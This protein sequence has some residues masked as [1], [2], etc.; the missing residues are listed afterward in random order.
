MRGIRGSRNGLFAILALA[1]AGS[2]ALV[3]SGTWS[4]NAL[5]DPPPPPAASAPADSRPQP[6]PAPD[7]RAIADARRLSDAFVQIAELVSPSVVS[8]KVSRPR[9]HQMGRMMPFQI[10]GPDFPGMDGGDAPVERGM[11][12]GVILDPQGHILTNNHVVARATELGVRLKDGRELPARLIGVDQ[13][14][15][16]AVIKVEAPN[17]RPARLGSSERMRVGDWV[18][19]IGSPFGLDYTVTAGVLSAKGRAG[20]GMNSVE[21]YLQTDASINPGNSGGPLVNLDA[22]VIGINTMIVGQGTGIGFAIPADMARESAR[23]LI[24]TGRVQRAWIGVGIQDLTPELAA[25]FRAEPRSG[26][27]LS[28]VVPGGPAARAGLAVGDIVTQIGAARVRSSQDVVRAVLTHRPGEQVEIRYV[29]SGRD[30]AARVTI[31]ERPG[32]EERSQVEPAPPAPRQPSTLGL[33]LGV[34]PDGRGVIMGIQPGGVADRAGLRPGD[35]IVEVDRRSVR[36]AQEAADR[37]RQSPRAL[38]RVERDGQSLFI[39]LR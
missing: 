37:L 6:T 35:V 7:S 21:D 18:V 14:A 3:G 11:G 10:P 23:Q 32:A 9:Q 8:I 4:H 16:L 5:A 29:R 13:A 19:A 22:E 36:T 39:P 2:L 33:Q 28:Q 24:A 20:I 15:D 38:L 30:S 27:L 12:S 1:A 34:A 25:S 31:G 17:L 26:A